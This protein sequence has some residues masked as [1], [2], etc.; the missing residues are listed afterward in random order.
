MN[1]LMKTKKKKKVTK[2]DIIAF[3][4]NHYVE[5]FLHFE[6]DYL[7]IKYLK[8]QLNKFLNNKKINLRLV[9]NYII[10]LNNVFDSPLVLVKILFMECDEETWPILATFLYFLR[11]SPKIIVVGTN[12][13]I[14][15]ENILDRGL[16][17]KLNEL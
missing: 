4:K 6:K 13:Y 3:A 9:L 15:V 17:E 1:C 11:L 8:V 14:M 2:E 10:T 7:I 5:S 16:L 12:H